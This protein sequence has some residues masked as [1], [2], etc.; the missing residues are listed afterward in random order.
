[1]R[2]C[3]YT[4]NGPSTIFKG[5]IFV[6]LSDALEYIDHAVKRGIITSCTPLAVYDGVMPVW[7]NGFYKINSQHHDINVRRGY[8]L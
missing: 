1:M 7:M 2:I 6:S 8:H 3:Q 5:D 4:N